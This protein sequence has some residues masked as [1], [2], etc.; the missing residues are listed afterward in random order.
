MAMT[1][2]GMR[3]WL[4]Q[5]STA[6]FMALYLMMLLTL[7]AVNRPIEHEVWQG[8]FSPQW[9]KM[10]TALFLFSL[11]I[12]AWLGVRN[13]LSDYIKS[14]SLRLGILAMV[15]TALLAYAVWTVKILWG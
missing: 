2:H 4:L 11:F 3:D 15:T 12:H 8:L 14:F 9:M 1:H 6:I 10:A 13:V 7:V 5:R